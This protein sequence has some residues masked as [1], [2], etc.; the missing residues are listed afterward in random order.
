MFLLGDDDLTLTPVKVKTKA[1]PLA[2][3]STH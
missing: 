1:Q 2:A 3:D